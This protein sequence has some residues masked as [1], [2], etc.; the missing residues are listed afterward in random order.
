MTTLGFFQS[1]EEI[2]GHADQT[3]VISYPNDRVTEPGDLKFAD[4]NKDGYVNAGKWTVDDPDDY[5]VIGNTSPRY[6]Y[7]YDFYAD[8]NNVDI[9]LFFQG[10]GKRDWYPA[11]NTHYFWGLYAM[12]WTNVFKEHMDHWTPGNR[13]P[14]FPRPESYIAWNQKELG[15][16][17]TKYLQ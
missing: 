15:A 17:Q 2:E 1:R 8:W 4:L 12:P 16:P 13:N 14:K 10:I 11:A 6:N 3:T 9:R 7:S 5:K